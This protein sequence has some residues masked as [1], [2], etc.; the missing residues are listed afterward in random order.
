M[1]LS[2]LVFAKSLR[3]NGSTNLYLPLFV[4]SN[5]FKSCFP[6]FLKTLENTAFSGVFLCSKMAFDHSFDHNSDFWA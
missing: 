6:H 2:A 3:R 1:C 5:K 4:H